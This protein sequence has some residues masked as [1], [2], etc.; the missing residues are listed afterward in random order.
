MS[1]SHRR[2]FNKHRDINRSLSQQ[3]KTS[4]GFFELWL[5]WKTINALVF[6]GDLVC[7][8]R[9]CSTHCIAK[10]QGGLQ[11]IDCPAIS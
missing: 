9:M 8:V 1:L 4:S 7:H 3:F 2:R 10:D 11:Y 6:K 5:V